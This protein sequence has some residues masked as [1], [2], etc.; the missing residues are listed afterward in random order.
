MSY[1]AYQKAQHSAENA[2]QVEYRLFAEVTNALM[3][4]KERATRDKQMVEALDWN[5]RM[6]SVLSSDC[7]TEGNG[8]PPQLRA[9]IISLSIWVSKHSSA[10]MRGEESIDDLININRTIMEGLADQAKLQQ[11]AQDEQPEP[12]PQDQKPINSLL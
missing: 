12:S 11:R 2:S 3:K 9:G 10:V 4:A 1:Q 5:R 6:W 8:L 7:G